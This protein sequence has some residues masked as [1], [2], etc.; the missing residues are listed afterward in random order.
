[1]KS[2]LRFFCLSWL[3]AGCTLGPNYKTPEM[4]ISDLWVSGGETVSI[5]EPL[6]RWWKIFGDTLLDGYIEQAVLYNNDVLAAE[7]NILQAKAARDVRAASFYPHFNLDLNATKSYFSKNGPLFIQNNLLDFSPTTG[8]PFEI[9]VPQI[10][11]LFN[12]LLD[13]VWEID[14]FGKTRRRVE[15]AESIF[16]STIAQR[17]AL[18]ISIMGELVRNYLEMR[19]LQKK[20]ELVQ[21][22]I[23]L[24]KIK[25]SIIESQWWVGYANLLDMEM[26][27]ASLASEEALL[28]RIKGEIYHRI[29]TIALLIG[30]VPETLVNELILPVPLPPIPQGIG[31]GLRSD[32]LRRRPDIRQSERSLAAAVADVGVAVASFFPSITLLGDGGFQS[33]K[34]KTL[35][36]SL[37]KTGTLGG[38]LN[39]PI[40]QGGR[41]MGNWRAA[42]A[43]A[44]SATYFYRQTVLKALEEAES[45]LIA[46]KRA[47]ESVVYY[48]EATQKYQELRRISQERYD[49]GLIPLINL[50]D[51]E[52]ELILS[53]E[54]LLNGETT[55]L[56]TLGWLYKTLG[57]G[58]E[59]PPEGEEVV[60]L[61]LSPVVEK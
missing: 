12:A 16:E 7:A 48:Q 22:N 19:S 43:A 18:L 40:F 24:L 39:L 46:Y 13:T 30:G 21:Q 56:V 49:R 27:E 15:A 42:Q 36:T 17:D 11:N 58:W 53:E 32:L 41:L 4:N 28:P 25:K 59:P 61:E 9:Q 3:L 52:R 29:Y 1:M 10:Q 45:A 44:V 6:S 31:V 38:D 55:A 50:L 8:L 5:E 20:E 33:L 26:I 35:F 60:T 57:G 23:N 34:L 2:L 37:S 47:V 54:A 51:V 14:L